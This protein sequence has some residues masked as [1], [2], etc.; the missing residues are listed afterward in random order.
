MKHI[1]MKRQICKRTNEGGFRGRYIGTERRVLVRASN[2][3]CVI[4]Q[5]C[6][7]ETLRT[8]WYCIV[9]FICAARGCKGAIFP[10]ISGISCRFVLSQTKYCYSV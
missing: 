2:K 3:Q 8:N 5:K 7:E 10:K 9:W 4:N 6:I 1:P